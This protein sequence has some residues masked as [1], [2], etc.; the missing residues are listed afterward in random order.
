MN[1]HVLW[2][3]EIGGIIITLGGVITYISKVIKP[4]AKASD[5]IKKHDERLDKIEADMKEIKDKNHEERLKKLESDMKEIKEMQKM[6][7]K[8]ELVLMEHEI[9][10]NSIEKLKDAKSE[11]QTFLIEKVQ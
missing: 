6:I 8:C 7:C 11:M 4:I 1:E 9:T 10:G 2:L 5:L 3:L